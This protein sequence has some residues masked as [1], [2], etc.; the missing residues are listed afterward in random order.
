MFK[1]SI[2]GSVF[3]SL[4]YIERSEFEVRVLVICMLVETVE[5][6]TALRRC[7]VDEF[8]LLYEIHFLD[9]LAEVAFVHFL[10]VDGLIQML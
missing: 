8:G 9:A 4:I 6:G 2:F 1:Y 10:T 7:L 3:N 5:R